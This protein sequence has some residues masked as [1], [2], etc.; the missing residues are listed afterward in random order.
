MPRLRQA[1]RLRVKASWVDNKRAQRP[2]D[3]FELLELLGFVGFV[4]SLGL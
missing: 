3:Q 4:G 2:F 1:G